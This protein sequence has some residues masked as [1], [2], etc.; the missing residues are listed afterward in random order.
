M[1]ALGQIASVLEIPTVILALRSDKEKTW[2][3]EKQIKMTKLEK[4]Q[5]KLINGRST[6]RTQ[7]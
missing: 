3:F 2:N 5:K 4:E 1:Q 7:K 6:L